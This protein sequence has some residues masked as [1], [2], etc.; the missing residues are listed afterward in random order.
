RTLAQAKAYHDRLDEET[1]TLVINL[2]LQD[3]IIIDR[4]AK[5][6]VCS[7]C[8][9]PHSLETSPPKENGSCNHCKAPLIQR[10]DDQEEIVRKRLTTYHTETAPLIHYY[11]EE[12]SLKRVSCTQPIQDVLG[13][14]LDSIVTKY[15]L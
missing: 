13:E 5:R 4:I 9:A 1:E 8:S 12:H 6:L 2:E 15:Y 7:T 11:S 3:D 10:T 14:I